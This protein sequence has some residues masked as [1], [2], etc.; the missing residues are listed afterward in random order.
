MTGTEEPVGLLLRIDAEPDYP[1]PAGAD[2]APLRDMAGGASVAR[3]PPLNTG[4]V[5]VSR[6]A[7]VPHAGFPRSSG[8]G[9]PWLRDARRAASRAAP[10]ATPRPAGCPGLV[11]RALLADRQVHRQVQE[12]VLAAVALRRRPGPRRHRRR[13]A[14]R[15]TRGAR[16][17]SRRRGSRALPSARRR[18]SWRTLAEEATYLFGGWLNIR[19]RLASGIGR[20]A[21]AAQPA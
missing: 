18:G 20:P 9:T 13:P 6:R 21:H 5:G 1:T 16:R 11:D 17:S 2:R 12:R 19:T 4:D 8:R 7:T 15:G 3:G 14:R 10:P